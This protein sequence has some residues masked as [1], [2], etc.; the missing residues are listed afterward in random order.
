M[1][2]AVA[3]LDFAMAVTG[4]LALIAWADEGLRTAVF[5]VTISFRDPLRPLLAALPLLLIRARLARVSGRPAPPILPAVP[6]VSV[7]LAFVGYVLL[8]LT[9]VSGG[10][11][12][13]GYV[14]AASLLR[15]ASLSVAPPEAD[16][17]PVGNPLEVLS[18][19]GYVP[20]AGDRSIVPIYPLGFP[21][22]IA[23]A[24]TILP[25]DLT[26][27]L[28][29]PVAAV[30]VLFLVFRIAHRWSHDRATAWLATALVA[31]DPLV[32]T[33]AKQPMSDVVATAWLLA[34]VW[35]LVRET[36]RPALAGV[37]AGV[38]F[39]TRP[40]GLGAVAALALL[41]VLQQPASRMRALAHFAAG[42]APWVAVQALLQ[43][44]LFGSPWQT[45]YGSLGAL[46]A[47]TSVIEN[48]RIYGQ[49][50]IS[51]HSLAWL[52]AVLAGLVALRRD[53]AAWVV[54]LLVVSIAPYLLYFRFD[55]WET[56]RFILPAV[57]LLDVCAA[58]GAAWLARRAL[59]IGWRPS[60]LVVA[61]V[62]ACLNAAAFLRAEGV[63]RLME[64]ERRYALTADWVAQHTAPTALVLSG[65][66]SGSIRHYAGRTTLRWDLMAPSDLEPVL[67][68]ARARG[69]SV[70]TA[71]D[72]AEQE[73]FDARFAQSL[74]RSTT[75]AP[76]TRLPGAQIGNV[77]V[78]EIVP[79]ENEP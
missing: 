50:L 8:H 48:L 5:G 22:V 78:W 69:I 49:A 18:P 23:L 58:A 12:S 3:L 31:W 79:R 64:Q 59:P 4:A 52:V 26:A 6:L 24:S 25:F 75:P 37:A 9:T 55:H 15:H 53:R 30:A 73:P 36:P 32:V 20:R 13:Y 33:Y 57:V 67:Q 40:G 54:T 34:A 61:A 43:W 70:Y 17:L 46:Y 71:L 39:L 7:V 41:T 1:S 65:Q 77:Q 16:W 66:H 10:A 76:L 44:H 29:A 38:S 2:R 56:L 42:V 35:A 11:D 19:L 45:G 74:G 72:R 63:P 51:I 68:S 62:L 60:A 14:S 27:Y 47:G 21:L 28:V